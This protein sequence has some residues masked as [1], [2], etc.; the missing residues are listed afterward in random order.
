VFPVEV[1]RQHRDE[2]EQDA[3]KEAQSLRSKVDEVCDGDPRG[4]RCIGPVEGP[5]VLEILG[6]KAI[7]RA[8]RWEA[9]DDR[10]EQEE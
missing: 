8:K 4:N 5:C 2:V 3:P 10:E 9:A 1:A 7:I 6:H